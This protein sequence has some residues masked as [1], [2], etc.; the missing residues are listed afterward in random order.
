MQHYIDLSKWTK[1]AEGAQRE[2]YQS[3]DD[4]DVLV[5]VIKARGRGERGARKS[6]RRLQW[7]RRFR[8]FGAYMTFRR[9]IDEY[10]EQARKVNSDEI[11]DLPIPRIL[12]LTHTSNGLGLLVERI[13]NRDG[14]LSPTLSQ[15][16]FSGR[17]TANHMQLVD[18]F[19]DRCRDSHIVLMDINP[20]N[21]VITDRSGCEEIF[22]IDGTGEKQFFKI[23]ASSRFLNNVR[24]K[25]AREKLLKKIARH[26][27]VAQERQ[28]AEQNAQP[29]AYPAPN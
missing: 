7:L 5:K 2:I 12:G 1:C 13:A 16:I 24:L 25:F 4:P 23:Y 15:L 8:R 9:E 18:Q 14:T 21:F 28:R 10:L 27:R 26:V 19:F 6:S 20:G 22:C 17:L 11:F 3:P 29:A